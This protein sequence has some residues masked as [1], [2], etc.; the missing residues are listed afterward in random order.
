MVCI[1]F[2]IIDQLL[3]STVVVQRSG[4]RRPETCYVGSA[5][6]GGDA[7]HERWGFFTHVGGVLQ[8]H[9]DL[10]FVHSLVQRDNVMKDFTPLVD[11]RDHLH[12]A[13]LKA[14]L[15]ALP[16]SLMGDVY[17]QAGV[18]IGHLLKPL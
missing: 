5:L 18:Q 4:Q 12:N 3:L 8:R 13:A 9:A 6:N 10:R 17:L 15:L 1:K 16:T 7:V 14:V 2:M 11:L